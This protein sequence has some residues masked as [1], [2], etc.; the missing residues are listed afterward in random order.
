[1]ISRVYLLVSCCYVILGKRK[2]LLF[3]NEFTQKYSIF[4]VLE[5]NF[6]YIIYI[7][8]DEERVE[9]NEIQQYNHMLI[10]IFIFHDFII[11]IKA[12]IDY[13]SHE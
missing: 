6:L 5:Y 4:F 8:N 11:T 10:T 2:V 7:T 9:I 3:R 1:M 13:F 12:N